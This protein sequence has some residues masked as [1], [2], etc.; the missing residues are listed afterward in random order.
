MATTILDA[1]GTPT[2]GNGGPWWTTF[3]S[4]VGPMNIIALGVVYVLAVNVRGD[5]SAAAQTAAQIQKDLTAHHAHTEQLHAQMEAYMRVQTLL[6]RQ[7]CA[8]AAK[9]ADDRSKCFSQ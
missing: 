9:S 5:A 4:K 6:T 3:I 2:N 7:L 8:N 1:N